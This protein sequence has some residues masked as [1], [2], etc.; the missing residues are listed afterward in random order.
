LIKISGSG[1]EYLVAASE[2]S[3][4]LRVFALQRKRKMIPVT[5]TDV[6]ALIQFKNGKTQKEEFYYGSSFLSQSSRFL[7]IGTNVSLIR[8]TDSKGNTRSLTF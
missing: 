3:G 1:G 4:P 5:P 6:S 7:T 8:I 2:H